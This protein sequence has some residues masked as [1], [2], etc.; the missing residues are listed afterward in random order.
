MR[1]EVERGGVV[2][3][4]GESRSEGDA[5]HVV[6][7]EAVDVDDGGAVAEVD[8][9]NE[10]EDERDDGVEQHFTLARFPWRHSHEREIRSA[11]AAS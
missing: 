6:L 11:A 3:E 9:G 4:A 5:G 2:V 7:D 1:R 10:D 8:A